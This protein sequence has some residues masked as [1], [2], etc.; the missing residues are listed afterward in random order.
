MKKKDIL[1][2]SDKE[3][4]KVVKIAGTQYDRKRKISDKQIESA[5]R[6]V[7]KGKSF[8]YRI[9][10]LKLNVTE[11]TIRYHLDEAYRRYRIDHANYENSVKPACCSQKDY[12]EILKDRAAYKRELVARGRVTV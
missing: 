4:D 8:E 5:K 10:K 2:L 7:K 1:E 12:N 11:N 3:L 6:L 9:K